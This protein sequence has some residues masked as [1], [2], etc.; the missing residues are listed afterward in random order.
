MNVIIINRINNQL[1]T[2]QSSIM[3]RVS[4]ENKILDPTSIPRLLDLR[5]RAHGP[6]LWP[7]VESG[8]AGS[9]S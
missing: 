9:K 3:G 1:I 5:S 7:G 4:D 2:S 8:H 6:G